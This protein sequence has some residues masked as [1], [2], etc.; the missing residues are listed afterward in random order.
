MNKCPCPPSQ[1]FYNASAYGFAAELERPA[2]HSIGSQ[3]ATVLGA[4]GGRSSTR[5][6]DFK[7]DGFLSVEDAHTEVGGSYDGCHNLHTTYAYSSL[8]G[9]NVGDVL[10][11]DRVVSRIYIYAPADPEDKSESSS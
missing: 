11:A 5:V 4:D 6:R 9:I 10:I 1:F 3:A 7:F 2:R 8:E